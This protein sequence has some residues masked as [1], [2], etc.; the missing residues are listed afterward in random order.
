MADST[1]DTE[2]ENESEIVDGL[3]FGILANM[4]FIMISTYEAEG[5]KP[6]LILY[7]KR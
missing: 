6:E 1:G 4:E 3:C 7:K 2:S 5:K